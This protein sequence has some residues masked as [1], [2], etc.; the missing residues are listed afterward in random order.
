M[1]EKV[2]V[3]QSKILILELM[4]AQNQLAAFLNQCADKYGP[5]LTPDEVVEG[6][7][8]MRRVSVLADRLSAYLDRPPDKLPVYSLGGV[9]GSTETESLVRP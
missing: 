7:E 8:L 5:V 9:G 1:S 2:S 4:E 3:F 6:R